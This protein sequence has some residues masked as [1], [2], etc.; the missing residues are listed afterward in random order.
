MI[1]SSLRSR[2]VTIA[3]DL[4]HFQSRD[5][6]DLISFIQADQL[7]SL[8][9]SALFAYIGNLHPD[10]DTAPARD[11]EILLFGYIKDSNQ[12]SILLRDIDRLHSFP[13]P[14]CKPVFINWC[15]L[16]KSLFAD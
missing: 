4:F 16:A 2:R 1:I 3:I 11:H 7:Y 5:A 9:R 8:R 6:R 10:N 15:A 12:F 13:T 14:V